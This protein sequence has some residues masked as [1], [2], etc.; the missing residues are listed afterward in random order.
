M[1]YQVLGCL[2]LLE[3]QIFTLTSVPFT[4]LQGNNV[5]CVSIHQS[6]KE[7][8]DKTVVFNFSLDVLFHHNSAIFSHTQAE[9]FHS[10]QALSNIPMINGLSLVSKLCRTCVLHG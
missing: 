3:S 7:T 1:G 2:Q 8:S 9:M 10:I 5:R 6:F 4:D